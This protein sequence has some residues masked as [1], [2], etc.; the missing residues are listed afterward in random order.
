M[1]NKL[2]KV[3]LYSYGLGDLASQFVWTFIGTYLTVFYTDVVG[4]APAIASMIMLVARILDVITD[5]IMGAVAERTT[6]KWG[7]FRPYILFGSPFLALF[8]VLTMTAPFGSGSAGIVWALFTYIFA[9]VFY[10][11]VNIPYSSLSA[12]MTTCPDERNKLNANRSAGMNI[13]MI[14][15]NVFSAGLLLYFSTQSEVADSRGYMFTAILY[16]V[17]SIPLFITV[18]KT[19]TEVVK[20]VTDYEN[21]TIKDSVKNVVG[22]KYLM[23]L[24][25][26]MFLQMLGF[27]GRIAVAAFYAI[28]CLGSFT[29]IAPLLTIPT[30]G[31]AIA[32]RFVAP[33]TR[34]FGKKRTLAVSMV[35]QALGLFIIYLAPFDNIPMI[36][37]GTVIFGIFNIGFPITLSMVADAVDYQ[38]LKSG[39]RTDGTAYATYGLATKLGNAIGGSLGI[40]LIASFGYI[41]NTEQAASTLAGI[42]LTVNLIPAILFVLA[43]CVLYFWK[44]TDEVAEEVRI[45]LN[46]EIEKKDEI[47]EKLK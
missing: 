45:C 17:I 33:L 1:N 21:V 40:M 44:I 34:K 14:I 9:G 35:L 41:A 39:V 25:A 26:V 47:L 29:L 28:Y 4:F 12:V 7:R 22:N 13:G 5:P 3:T 46:E 43:A 15:I 30:I 38:E 42:N 31:G 18:F 6:S 20:P 23:I 11:V 2:S 24:M 19:S 27:M 10:T 36:L 32:S 37:A 8:T 16:A